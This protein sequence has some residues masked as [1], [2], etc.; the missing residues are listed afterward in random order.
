MNKSSLNP[1][2]SQKARLTSR[3][4]LIEHFLSYA[5]VR[6]RR[7]FKELADGKGKKQ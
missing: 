7:K 3:N 1:V 4:A 2:A 6:R 5:A